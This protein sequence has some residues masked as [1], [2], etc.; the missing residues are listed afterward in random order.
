MNNSLKDGLIHDGLKDVS[1]RVKTR[2]I[3]CALWERPMR[4]QLV[5]SV[6][7]YQGYDV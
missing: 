1:L 2:L 6:M 5:G 3:F 4:Y 7:D